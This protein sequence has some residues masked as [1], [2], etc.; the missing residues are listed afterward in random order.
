VFEVLGLGFRV[1]GLG[2]KPNPY[3]HK[4]LDPK[5]FKNPIKRSLGFRVLGCRV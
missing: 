2:R 4:I 5:T 1:K 3:N